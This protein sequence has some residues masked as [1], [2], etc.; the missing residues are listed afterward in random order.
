MIRAAEDAQVQQQLILPPSLLL[1]LLLLLLMPSKGWSYSWIIRWRAD[2]RPD[3][4]L[5][6]ISH[7]SIFAMRFDVLITRTSPKLF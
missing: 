3:R 1:L 4:P 7:V 6:H 5:P 2:Y